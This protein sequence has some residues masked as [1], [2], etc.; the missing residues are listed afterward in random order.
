MLTHR[1]ISFLKTLRIC[2]PHNLSSG[3]LYNKNGVVQV[4]M[5]RTFE[6]RFGLID[7]MAILKNQINEA[8][9]NTCG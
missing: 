2:Q 1:H 8:G 3:T 6:L 5:G 9:V 7:I 4:T